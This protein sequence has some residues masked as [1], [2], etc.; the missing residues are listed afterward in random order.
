MAVANDEQLHV[1]VIDDE[2][3]HAEIVC[4]I[5]ERAGYRCTI[6][7]S[8]KEGARRIETDQFD[9]ILTDLKMGDLDGLAI[10]KKAKESDPDAE[11]MVITGYGDVKTA[12]KALQ[13]GASHYMLKP[14]DKNELLTVVGKSAADLRRNRVLR[15]L[16]EIIRVVGA[17][18]IVLRRR[19]T[20]SAG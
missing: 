7:T 17:G 20:A 10:I 16:Y 6:A 18:Q 12:V 1:L 13:E 4:E 3:A 5:L 19:R 8:G 15:D 9:L 2:K 11:V 14:L